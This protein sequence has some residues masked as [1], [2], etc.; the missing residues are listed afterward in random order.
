[1]FKLFKDERGGVVFWIVLF[2]FLIAGLALIMYG[3]NAYMT[4]TICRSKL[5]NALLA[6]INLSEA[7][8]TNIDSA[9]AFPYFN[10]YL[11]KN[12][13]LNSDFTPQ[14]NSIAQGKVEVVSYYAIN[15]VPAVDPVIG[16]TVVKPSLEAV[17][18]VPVLGGFSVQVF[19]RASVTS[20]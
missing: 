6:G 11:Q 4:K 1:M 2:P 16:D 20:Q 3:G 14:A 10:T 9:A 7:T 19:S 12:L 18:K 15:N 17:I 5:E 13:N 8:I